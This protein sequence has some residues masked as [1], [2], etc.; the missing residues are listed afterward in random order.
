[1]T[2]PSPHAALAESYD[3][4]TST[5]QRF[6]NGSLLE[7]VLSVLPQGGSVLDVGCA[8]GGL[9]AALEGSAGRRVGLEISRS[10]AEEA[11]HVADDV[12]VGD[13]ADEALDLGTEPF[14]V[15][16]LADV[17]EHTAEPATALRQVLRFCQPTTRI[18]V[19]VP[20]VAHWSA[21]MQLGRGRW[22][23]TES[24]LMDRGHLRFFTTSTIVAELLAAG[25]QVDGVSPVVPRLR[26]HLPVVERLPGRLAALVER[27]W[28][29]LGRKR[30]ELMAYQLVVVA[31]PGS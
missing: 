13:I 7:V 26:N 22:D 5:Y 17:L 27:L 14:D 11:R 25:L 6:G 21:R 4:R 31:R 3:A 20:N 28:Q 15:V 18:V 23:Y 24:G 2:A 8:S 29:R 1:M 30:L 16:V 19:S 12:V 9:L 10:A